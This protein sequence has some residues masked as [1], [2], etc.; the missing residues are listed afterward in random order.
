MNMCYNP[1]EP[2]E[3][4]HRG[5]IDISFRLSIPTELYNMLKDQIHVKD[6]CG[7]EFKF[8]SRKNGVIGMVTLPLDRATEHRH[9]GALLVKFLY[10]YKMAAILTHYEELATYKIVD[11]TLYSRGKKIGAIPKHTITITEDGKKLI[12]F[13]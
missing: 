13:I 2:R 3:V 4:L 8:F 9:I 6:M 10:Q 7:L 12:K 5:C 11:D 1:F